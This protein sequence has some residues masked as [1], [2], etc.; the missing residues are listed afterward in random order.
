MLLLLLAAPLPLALLFNLIGGAQRPILGVLLGIGGIVLAL[1]ALRRGRPKH[2]AIL[3][4]V[5]TGLLAALAC[6]A[7]VLAA[8]VFGAMAFLGTRLLYE[9]VPEAAPEV[10]ARPDLLAVP[11]SRLATLGSAPSRLRPA[12]V[13]LGELLGELEQRPDPLPEARRFLTV[14]LDGL[15][16]IAQKLRAGA[17]PPVALDELVEEMAR[18]SAALRGRL[19]AEQQ[20]ALEIQVK[21]LSDRLREEG[22]A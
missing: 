22:F 10:P 12:V 19:R 5:G 2:A 11:R 15:E 13:A 4:G 1:R 7:P 6:N 8:L 21:V 20:D 3:V 16:R 14:Q 18:A 9:G 17:V